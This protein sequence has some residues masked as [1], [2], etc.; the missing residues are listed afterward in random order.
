MNNNTIKGKTPAG[1]VKHAQR[2][3]KEKW[4]YVWGTYGS[5]LTEELLEM[6]A[7]QYPKY[8]GGAN[9][10]LHRRHLGQT[11]SDC[12]GLIKGYC[13][14]DERQ[15]RPIYAPAL[16]Y[17][18]GMMYNAATVKGPI[19][20]IPDEPGICV[21]MQGHVGV[22]VGDGWVIECAGGRGAVRTPLAGAGATRWTAWF[23]CPFIDYVPR[24]E[25][26]AGPL[27]V[28]DRVRVKEGSGQYGGGRLSGWVYNSS[29][30]ILELKGSR[31]VI[32]QNGRVTAA[33]NVEN[34][35]R[36]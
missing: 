15:D 28:G 27:Q 7:K 19:G 11:V 30:T 1:L 14:W 2:A 22:Y 36:A 26:P 25:K 6:K 34:L 5:L 16:D 24:E 13:M 35:R 23:Q 3:V 9:K 18:T 10:E 33:V 29:F 8:N 20:T 31:A 21:Y 17:N 12:V 32:G 4:W